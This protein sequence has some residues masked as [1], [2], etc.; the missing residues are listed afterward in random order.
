MADDDVLPL[1]DLPPPRTPPARLTQSVIEAMSDEFLEQDILAFVM[2]R[3]QPG[4]PAEAARLASLPLPLQAFYST[5]IVEA[6]VYNGGFN[7]LFYNHG[8]AVARLAVLGYT[9]IRSPA[10]SALVAEAVERL[11]AHMPELRAAWQ[12]DTMEAFMGSYDLQV[13][14]DLDDRFVALHDAEEGQALRIKY[15]RQHAASLEVD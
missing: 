15:I 14:D 4:R 6:E 9:A 12:D 3:T 13:F 11:L 1:F 8:G 10:R 5:F 2:Q 7:Q